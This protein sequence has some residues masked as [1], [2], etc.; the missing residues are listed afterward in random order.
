MY[1]NYFII[2]NEFLSF[3]PLHDRER[4]ADY[5]SDSCNFAIPGSGCGNTT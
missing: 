5:A 1:A 2:D 4:A 3:V